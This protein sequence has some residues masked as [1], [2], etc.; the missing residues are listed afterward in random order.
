[1][2]SEAG[3]EVPSLFLQTWAGVSAAE[4]GCVNCRFVRVG[5]V[6]G[7]LFMKVRGAPALSLLEWG[8]GGQATASR[9]LS[10]LK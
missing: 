8:Q 9:A 10:S 7:C 4:S 1:M 2:A 3:L 5:C 6:P